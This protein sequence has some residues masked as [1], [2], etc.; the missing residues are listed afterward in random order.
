MHV[1][2]STAYWDKR[3]Q[4]SHYGMRQIQEQ[5]HVYIV[6]L[7]CS[8]CR[9][10]H[11]II[12]ILAV[13]GLPPPKMTSGWIYKL[14][15]LRGFMILASQL[16]VFPGIPLCSKPL[17]SVAGRCLSNFCPATI[18]GGHLHCSALSTIQLHPPGRSILVYL[19]KGLFNI[20]TTW[21]TKTL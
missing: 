14:R 21:E 12:Q 3:W 17:P 13:M 10:S 16:L 5:P 19:R 6:V 15:K 1:F 9:S 11:A 4:W 8:L 18:S 2:V 20:W 7:T